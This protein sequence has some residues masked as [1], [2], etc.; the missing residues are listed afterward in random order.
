VS[1]PPRDYARAARVFAEAI[2]ASGAETTLYAIARE[3]GAA[4]GRALAESTAGR[5]PTLGELQGELAERGYEPYQDAAGVRLRNCPFNSV[6]REFPVVA[7]GMN[8]ALV[9]GLLAGFGLAA[10]HA[11]RLDPRPGECCVMIS[12]APET[13]RHRSK[14]NVN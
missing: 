11:A 5:P 13:P 3:D 14:T 9:E 8:L 12:S 6:A 2:E 1:L 7:C 4:A 10:T